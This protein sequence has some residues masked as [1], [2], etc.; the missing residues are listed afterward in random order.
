M[1]SPLRFLGSRKDDKIYNSPFTYNKNTEILRNNVI[2]SESEE[3]L[4]NIAQDDIFRKIT[5][6]SRENSL[7]IY[8]YH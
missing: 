1:K 5:C 7:F 6:T 3:S 8:E 4:F 2:L